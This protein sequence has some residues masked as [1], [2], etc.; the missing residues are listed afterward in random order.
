MDLKKRTLFE[1][2]RNHSHPLK[3]QQHITIF[4]KFQGKLG[5]KLEIPS[6]LGYGPQNLSDYGLDAQVKINIF[7]N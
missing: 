5:M 6:C 3:L 2:I 4:H 7:T 1:K